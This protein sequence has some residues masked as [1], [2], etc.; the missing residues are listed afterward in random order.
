MSE[1]SRTGREADRESIAR[2]SEYVCV[3]ERE[4]EKREREREREREKR[5]NRMEINSLSLSPLHRDPATVARTCAE[6]TPC[7]TR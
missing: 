3:C 4:R 2:V 7:E 6:A 5:T 1:I